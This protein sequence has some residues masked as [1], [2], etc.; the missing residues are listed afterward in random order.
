M[1]YAGVPYAFYAFLVLHGSTLNFQIPVSCNQK[2]DLLKGKK[3]FC[4]A[5]LILLFRITF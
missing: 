2:A 3:L 5:F 4:E 1:L